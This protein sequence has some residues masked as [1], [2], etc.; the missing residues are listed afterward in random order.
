MLM[1]Y[2][3]RLK[4]K[5]FDKKC[6]YHEDFLKGERAMIGRFGGGP[7]NISANEGLVFVFLIVPSIGIVLGSGSLWA[8]FI[9]LFLICGGSVLY[10]LLLK[11][12]AKR[13]FDCLVGQI[14]NFHLKKLKYIQSNSNLSNYIIVKAEFR[15]DAIE[16]FIKKD[17]PLDRLITREIITKEKLD[18]IEHDIGTL[19]I[20]FRDDYD[21]LIA[22]EV[23]GFD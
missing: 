11:K 10:V 8:A 5:I 14:N 3:S 2:N 17:G 20:R 4:L 9:Y 13:K 6:V 23:Q 7:V 1:V 19:I 15:L 12:K 18:S 21:R 22:I 16:L